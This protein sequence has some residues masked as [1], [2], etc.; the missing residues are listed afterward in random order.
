M[1]SKPRLKWTLWLLLAGVIATGCTKKDN[2]TG[3]N[4]SGI[5]TLSVTDTLNIGFGYSYPADEPVKIKG[6]EA[7][8]LAANERSATS[9]SYLRFTG[10]PASR[11][12]N[13]IVSDSCYIKIK[14]LKS[15]DLNRNPLV[16]SLHKVNKALPDTID[17]ALAAE[18]IA[19][20]LASY[21]LGDSISVA[22]KEIKFGLDTGDLIPWE[23]ETDSTGWN[24]ALKIDNGWVEIASNETVNGPKLN[25][26]YKTSEEGAWNDVSK[27]PDRDTYFLEA[28]EGMASETWKID[29]LTSTR[30]YIKYS[31]QDTLNTMFRDNEGNLLS[32]TELKRMTVNKAVLVLHVKPNTNTYY[33]GSTTFS[34]YPFN[35]VKEGISGITNLVKAD[36]EQILGTSASEKTVE[37]DQVEIDITPLIQAYTSGDKE[38][39]GIMIQSLQERQNFGYLEFYDNLSATPS[40]KLPYVRI[41]YTP[42]FL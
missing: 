20:P 32:L 2:L 4:W 10:L 24:L 36:Y 13:S 1:D 25:L 26:R 19:E 34:L 41:I 8:L 35:V 21:T 31:L 3:N 40:D 11:T 38:P 6:T 18:I 33:T 39:L 23:T 28:P 9:I 17:A 7:K 12:I 37:N 5:D 30:L 29:N 22:G 15:S 14:L 27:K 42:P 16:I